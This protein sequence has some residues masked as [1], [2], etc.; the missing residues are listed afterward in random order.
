MRIHA[1]WQSRSIAFLYLTGSKTFAL[2]YNNLGDLITRSLELNCEG[3]GYNMFEKQA[4]KGAFGCQPHQPI[5]T[6]EHSQDRK[7]L[8]FWTAIHHYA[9]PC[10]K[11]CIYI[12]DAKQKQQTYKIQVKK[13]CIKVQQWIN[14][15][16]KRSPG[17]YE[18]ARN[19]A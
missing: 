19:R 2:F 16:A 1:Q 7:C 14:D 3:P 9:K 13:K 5:M 4:C 12:D 10:L 17:Y 8:I 18:L 11:V 6:T 15:E